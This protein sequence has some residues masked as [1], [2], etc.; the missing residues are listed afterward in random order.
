MLAATLETVLPVGAALAVVGLVA[1]ALAT[2]PL[3][4]LAGR[5]GGIPGAAFAG[6]TLASLPL[7]HRQ[8]LT[9]DARGL[10]LALGIGAWAL[11]TRD[12]SWAR[13]GLGGLLAGFAV[14]AR[15]EAALA[16]LLVPVVAGVRWRDWRVG[17]VTAAGVAAVAGPWWAALSWQADAL[18]LT[19]RGVEAWSL[20]LL[21][22]LPRPDVEA[23]VGV[24]AVETP[25]RT[26]AVHAGPPPG[27][28]ALDV[29]GGLAWLATSGPDAGGLLAWLAPLGLGVALLARRAW[30]IMALTGIVAPVLAATMLPHGRASLAE[31][32]PLTLV[33]ATLVGG[34]VGATVRGF[35]R[36]AR[37]RRKPWIAGGAV[38]A[39]L[40][41][42]LIGSRP[43]PAALPSPPAHETLA[44][45]RAV[46]HYLRAAPVGTVRASLAAAPLV[47]LAERPWD[48]WPSVWDVEAWTDPER[49]P[50][51]LLVTD[52]DPD[53]R[54][55]L[56]VEDWTV[57]AVFGDETAWALVLAPAGGDP[58]PPAAEEAA[59]TPPPTPARR[60][61]PARPAPRPEKQSPLRHDVPPL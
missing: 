51:R 52:R 55:A 25:F 20:P 47:H 48:P 56:R 42:M 9:A 58:A 27:N 23:L 50:V 43:P 3:T 53:W 11:V 54:A 32:L 29:R 59:S 30:T 2:V 14:L 4:A 19:P 22:V 57:E 12:G 46:R 21:D 26:A 18:A 35:W 45:G 8:A 10:A 6:V 34:A 24:S 33:A 41:L 15:S 37:P 61:T 28:G 40:L 49:R 16:A 13:A 7:L 36:S 5:L 44:V 39:A 31:L 17:L 60:A 1:A 38:V